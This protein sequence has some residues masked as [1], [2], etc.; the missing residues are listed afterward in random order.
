M[1]EKSSP[2]SQHNRL[3]VLLGQQFSLLNNVLFLHVFHILAAYSAV[4][5]EIQW[6]H[7]AQ[8]DPVIRHDRTRPQDDEGSEEDWMTHVTI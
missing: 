3:L 6:R 7:D 8:Q 1:I 5:E 4:N 2:P